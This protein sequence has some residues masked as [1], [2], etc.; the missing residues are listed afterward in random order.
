MA[1]SRFVSSFAFR[2]SSFR[3]ATHVRSLARRPHPLVRCLGHPQ[4][5]RSRREVKESHQF[6]D[7]PARF[8][9]AGAGPP[10]GD[11]RHPEPQE[12]LCPFARHARAARK[13]PVA[14]PA[15][16]WPRRPRGVRYLRHQRRADVGPV[17]AAESGRGSDRFR[18]LLRDVRRALGGRRRQGGLYRHLSRFP[19]RSG[20]R[21]GRHY[22]ADEGHH[23]QQPRQSDGRS[24]Q[25]GRGSRPGRVG[26][27][28]QRGLDQRRDLSGLLLRR[29]VRF[30]GE[31]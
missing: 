19:H 5:F 13:T 14:N 21:G 29:A 3:V 10:G 18:S 11:R 23:L 4:G 15:A 9:R 7:W 22:A 24:G 6:V 8:R 25:R 26:R 1:F 30:A 31:V 17:G 12:R 27:P 16:V 20:A 2:P 28:A